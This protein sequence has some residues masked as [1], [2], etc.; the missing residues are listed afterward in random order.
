MINTEWFSIRALTLPATAIALLLAFIIVW[1]ILRMQFSKQWAG[2]Y[3]DAIFTFII[4]WKFSVIVTDFSTII[5]Q[6]IGLIYFNGGTPGVYF[7]VVAVIVQFLWKKQKIQLDEEGVTAVIWSILLTQS[8]YQWLVVLLNDNP[9]KSEVVTLLVLSILTIFIL[10]KKA[11]RY[12]VL[13]IYTVVF[14]IV[15]L[16][17]PLGLWQTAVGVSMLLLVLGYIMIQQVGGRK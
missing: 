3:G 16:F 13:M 12:Y 9:L 5:K 10:W 15:A 4:V 8:F 11:V 6:P 2:L 7:G 17:Q 1:F 14:V